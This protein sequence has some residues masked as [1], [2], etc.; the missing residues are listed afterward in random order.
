MVLVNSD[1]V[2]D[3]PVLIEGTLYTPRTSYLKPIIVGDILFLFFR[4]LEGVGND[5][6]TFLLSFFFSF[7]PKELMKKRRERELISF[8]Y[9]YIYIYIY[10]FTELYT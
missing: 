9:S 10:I 5:L 6:S 4:G 3:E 1:I 7:L 2:H 8:H